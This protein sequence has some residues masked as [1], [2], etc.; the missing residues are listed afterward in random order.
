MVVTLVAARRA[1]KA[2]E[3]EFQWSI[4]TI[5]LTTTLGY[6]FLQLIESYLLDSGPPHAYWAFVGLMLAASGSRSSP[7]RAVGVGV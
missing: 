5:V 3:T 4:A 6:V 7:N 2:A 1:Q